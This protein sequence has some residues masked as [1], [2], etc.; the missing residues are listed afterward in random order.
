MMTSLSKKKEKAIE[1]IV[2]CNDAGYETSAD[3]NIL[4]TEFCASHKGEALLL[5]I[6]TKKIPKTVAQLRFLRGVLFKK[7]AEYLGYADPLDLILEFKEST[8]MFEIKHI[9]RVGSDEIRMLK[10]YI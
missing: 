6:S 7:F 9:K 1:I 10:D 3:N 2:V 8:A 5:K 4:I